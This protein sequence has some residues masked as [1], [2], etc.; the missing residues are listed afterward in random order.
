MTQVVNWRKRGDKK[1]HTKKSDDKLPRM[2]SGRVCNF[3]VSFT[4]FYTQ[5]VPINALHCL[6]A[7]PLSFACYL[8]RCILFL[9]LLGKKRIL[10]LFSMAMPGQSGGARQ[11]GPTERVLLCTRGRASG[12][13][14]LMSSWVLWHWCPSCR[15]RIKETEGGKMGKA[16]E[17]EPENSGFCSGLAP[18]TLT[19]F[20]ASDCIL[21][22]RLLSSFI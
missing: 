3:E 19:G 10:K 6:T 17:K 13:W 2:R 20:E 5:Q 7:N 11:R 21:P 4:W 12:F 16:V 1:N 15:I 9:K 8:L 22:G 18:T 14:F